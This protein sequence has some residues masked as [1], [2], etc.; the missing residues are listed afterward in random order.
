VSEQ[1]KRNLVAP[2]PIDEEPRKMSS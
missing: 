2:Q 1:T